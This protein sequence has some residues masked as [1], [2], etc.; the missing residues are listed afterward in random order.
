MSTIFMVHFKDHV[1]GLSATSPKI[2]NGFFKYSDHLAPLLPKSPAHQSSFVRSP[3]TFSD[4]Q[5]IV[6]A[7]PRVLTARNWL[8]MYNSFKTPGPAFCT[9]TCG[10][11]RTTRSSLKKWECCGCCGCYGRGGCCGLLLLLARLVG[12]V[13]AIYCRCFWWWICLLSLVAVSA[14]GAACVAAVRACLMLVPVGVGPA[15]LLDP[16]HLALQYETQ[17]SMLKQANSTLNRKENQPNIFP[18]QPRFC[19][20]H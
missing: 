2:N 16:S 6:F 3:K 1:S 4:F 15:V 14:C 8:R 9:H 5:G 10:Q 18:Q 17:F 13:L 12:F 7:T 19:P 20:T 11:D